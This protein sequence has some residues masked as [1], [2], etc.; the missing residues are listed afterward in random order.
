MVLTSV[1]K[2]V[3]Y[4][5]WH[6]FDILFSHEFSVG[7]VLCFTRSICLMKVESVSVCNTEKNTVISLYFLVWKLGEITVF[8]AV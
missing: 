4:K 3:F 7:V 6:G 8:F 1:R 5:F 2:K